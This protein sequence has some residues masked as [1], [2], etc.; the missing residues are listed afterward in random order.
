M[1]SA[2][3]LWFYI[4]MSIS[5][6]ISTI[7]F[8]SMFSIPETIGSF[9]DFRAGKSYFSAFCQSFFPVSRLSNAYCLTRNLN[10][11][12]ARTE[13][14]GQCRSSQFCS[15]VFCS[16]VSFLNYW[17]PKAV[18]VLQT[19]NL[20][21]SI[22]ICRRWHRCSHWELVS[23]GHQ[24]WFCENQQTLASGR[25]RFPFGTFFL[26]GFGGCHLLELHLLDTLSYFGLRPP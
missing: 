2:A 13:D 22:R 20:I 5:Y 23:S 1:L 19:E 3:L 21:C 8:F 17:F 26:A 10:A 24:H 18:S 25:D 4:A 11:G 9:N 12:K 6:L 15:H 16:L 14:I 7:I